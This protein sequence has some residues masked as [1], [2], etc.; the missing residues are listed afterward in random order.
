MY[1]SRHAGPDTPGRLYAQIFSDRA[2]TQLRA[3][4]R[5][6]RVCKGCPS[7]PFTPPFPFTQIP[8]MLPQ[9]AENESEREVA[10]LTAYEGLL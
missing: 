3:G 8:N 6:G 5:E 9:A 2:L 4:G 10:F 7:S 1:I